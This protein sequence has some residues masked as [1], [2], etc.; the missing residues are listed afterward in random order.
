MVTPSIQPHY[1]WQIPKNKSI[2]PIF[3]TRDLNCL[4]YI[5]NARG[6]CL[7]CDMRI[8]AKLF[9]LSIC[10]QNETWV[11]YSDD[12]YQTSSVQLGRAIQHS[13]ARKVLIVPFAITVRGALCQ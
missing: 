3:F 9:N 12:K 1:L 11:L 4:R 13:G 8:D 2:N 5:Q 7:Y 6:I 10:Y